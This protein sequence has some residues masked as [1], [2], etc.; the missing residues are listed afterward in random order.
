M[1]NVGRPSRGCYMCRTRRVKCDE[2]KP[3]CMNCEKLKK[4]CPGYRSP[5]D[6]ILR[7]E[8]KA[9]ERKAR[10]R[11]PRK[12][13]KTL[14][15]FDWTS[16]S[17]DG[18]QGG[19]SRSSSISSNSSICSDA[20]SWSA[21]SPED[22][23]NWLVR[24]SPQSRPSSMYQQLS[25]PIEQQA[26]NYFFSNFVLLPKG[27]NN[28][29]YMTYLLPLMKMHDP[30]STFALSLN[31]VALASFGNRSFS[32]AV[33]PRASQEYAK[34]L[35]QV[36][37]ALRDPELVKLDHTLASVLLL[38]LFETICS[39]KV[40]MGWNDH[41]NG[42]VALV[43]MRG[44]DIPTNAVTRELH[45]TV[46]AQMIPYCI[47]NSRSLDLPVE[48]WMS[49]S[50][51]GMH[52][53]NDTNLK[54]VDL[55]TRTEA[56]ISAAQR[57]PANFEK[58]LDIM[59]RAEALENEYLEWIKSLPPHWLFKTV[60]WNDNMSEEELASSNCFS[61]KVDMYAGMWMAN[62]WN[63][64]RAC[65]LLLSQITVRCTAWLCAPRDYRTTPEYRKA[66]RLCEEL[67]GDM[68]ASV[69]NFLGG[70][71]RND[72]TKDVDT[73]FA[74]PCGEDTGTAGKGISGLF[75][76]WPLIAAATSDFA[77]E[78]QRKWMITKLQFVGDSI[79]INQGAVYSGFHVRQ[80]SMKIESDRSVFNKM[81]D[82]S[83]SISF[84]NWPQSK[85][86]DGMTVMV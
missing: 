48:W 37:A 18:S 39:S 69:P 23:S 76:L 13:S 6:T 63:M 11:K 75:L 5:I 79:G 35:R 85:N 80:P 28:F 82:A 52:G 34:A 74:F 38:G 68:I 20:V 56:V 7:N 30:G 70:L 78:A 65:R 54:V 45:L 59:H 58:V 10:A 42:A 29:G 81:K 8:T 43:K 27:N 15:E 12:T 57:T 53:C 14:P 1:V 72:T 40:H 64:S 61:G 71:P 51:E 84:A 19:H 44:T 50:L 60:A 67:I 16:V 86:L 24:S 77:T 4:E 33:L 47:L 25:V 22:S 41:M 21:E 32:K 26:T 31:A 49:L 2:R 3:G 73:G 17:S 66:A 62:L 9:T 46:R 55:R 36:N 83:E